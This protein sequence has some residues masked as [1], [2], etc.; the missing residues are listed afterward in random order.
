MVGK[1]LDCIQDTNLHVIADSTST[2]LPIEAHGSLDTSTKLYDEMVLK[3][4]FCCSY[5]IS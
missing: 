3:E 5:G 2:S 4:L 1:R